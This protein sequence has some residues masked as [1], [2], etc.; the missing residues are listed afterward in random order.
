LG[1]GSL[2]ERHPR[3]PIAGRIYDLLLLIGAWL[4][5]LP[6]PLAVPAQGSGSAVEADV[7]NEVPSSKPARCIDE[8]LAGQMEP[9]PVAL[10]EES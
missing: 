2:N 5:S 7:P 4:S 10:C 3:D 8:V 1:T 9:Y 6:G